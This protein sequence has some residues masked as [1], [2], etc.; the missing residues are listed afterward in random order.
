MGLNI[1]KPQDTGTLK[2]PECVEWS[3][4]GNLAWLTGWNITP[5]SW[6]YN[7]L[8]FQLCHGYWSLDL[9]KKLLQ[10]SAFNY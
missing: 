2:L 9:R 6:E 10:M 8:N 3:K 4:G 5:T 7:I 1:V